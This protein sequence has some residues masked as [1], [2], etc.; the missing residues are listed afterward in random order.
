MRALIVAFSEN[1]YKNFNMYKGLNSFMVIDLLRQAFIK[2]TGASHD[3]TEILG[4]KPSKDEICEKFGWITLKDKWLNKA[5][6]EFISL[7]TSAGKEKILLLDDSI[8]D[9]DVENSTNET[10][11]TLLEE[12]IIG[13][14]STLAFVDR[15]YLKKIC[16]RDYSCSLTLMQFKNSLERIRLI[17][18]KTSRELRNP[19]K[20]INLKDYLDNNIEN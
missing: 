8:E 12:H 2:S 9:E 5:I 14:L 18:A 1:E 11:F 6:L 7:N 10:A 17:E 20:R 15:E 4:R 3:L 19:Q 16:S 13:S